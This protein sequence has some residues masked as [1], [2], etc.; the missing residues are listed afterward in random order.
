MRAVII[1]DLHL[2]HVTLG[3]PREA[4][5]RAAVEASVNHALSKEVDLWVC[6]G[7]VMDPDC[8]PQSFRHVEFLVRQA[9]LLA[10]EGIHSVFVAGNHDVVED[11]HGGTTLSPLK[12]VWPKYV[13]VIDEPTILGYGVFDHYGRPNQPN[14]IALPFTPASRPYDPAEFL[15]ASLDDQRMNL[16]LSHLT[17]VEGVIPGEEV[18]DMPRGREV[19][20]PLEL[21][22]RPDVL[23]LQGHFHRRQVHKHQGATVHI[24]GSPTRFTF[25]EQSHEPAFMVVEC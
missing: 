24:C 9:R 18:T 2:D 1:S 20:L 17:G 4:E 12:G 3:V 15:R 21:L 10:E 22:A 5:V 14:V 6:L 8:G 11:S 19:T 23:V 13:H 16:V 7:D 25:G